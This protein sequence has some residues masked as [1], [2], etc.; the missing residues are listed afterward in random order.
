MRIRE[1]LGVVGWANLSMFEAVSIFLAAAAISCVVAPAAA[2]LAIPVGAVSLPVTDRWHRRPTPMLGG[3][4]IA[5]GTL[6]AMLAVRAFKALQ[7]RDRSTHPRAPHVVPAIRYQLPNNT[8]TFTVAAPERGIVALT[9]AYS[10][11][12]SSVTLKGKP[13]MIFSVNH[14]FK[15]V[16]IDV[17]ATYTV[18]VCVLAST[19]FVIGPRERRGSVGVVSVVVVPLC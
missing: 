5:S 9:E 2:W 7:V 4:A 18:Y 3:I 6:G 8:T 15:G 16:E 11:G 14:R 17:P 10:E 19:L 1:S 12:D 13:A